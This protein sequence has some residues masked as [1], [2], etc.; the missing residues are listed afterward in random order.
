MIKRI[1]N[2][3]F[4][5]LRRNRIEEAKAKWLT[6]HA[7]PMSEPPTDA[8]LYIAGLLS[9]HAGVAVFARSKLHEFEKQRSNV[10]GID[11]TAAM[12]QKASFAFSGNA[13][14]CK[15]LPIDGCGTVI[16]H[17][18]PPDFIPALHTMGKAFLRD[19][20]IIGFWF[21]EL[22]KLPPWW[23][24]SLDYLHEIWVGSEF[25]ANAVRIHTDKPVKVRPQSLRFQ[26]RSARPF[27]ADGKVRVLYIF[28]CG[29]SYVRKNPMAAVK[30]FQLAFGQS[31]RA[32]LV[33]KVIRPEMYPAGWQELQDAA[34]ENGNIQLINTFMSQ[35]ELD[36]LYISSDIYLSLH[37][38][39]GYGLTIQEA[40]H[41]G[42]HSIATGWSGN[43]DFMSGPRC[44]LVDY[45]LIPVVDPQ[46]IYPYPDCRWAEPDIQQAADMLRQIVKQET[47]NTNLT[48]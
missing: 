13:F 31:N 6:P 46:S 25:V 8:P 43:L 41:F 35:E 18:N 19:K 17:L 37:R 4:P 27:A 15:N 36:E 23:L 38:S 22:E 30:A 5:A 33:M 34:K 7:R 12:H 11:L 39:E 3:L 16:V 42:L 32:E 24:A 10:H 44:H 20:Y 26:P 1:V 9:S 48:S 14:D 21:W 45:T 2:F 47:G 29:S 28:D 40:M